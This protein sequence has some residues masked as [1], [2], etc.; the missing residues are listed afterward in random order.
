M[1]TSYKV[2]EKTCIACP[3]QL[4]HDAS[5]GLNSDVIS[6]SMHDHCTLDSQQHKVSA[7]YLV[8]TVD[9]ACAVQNLVLVSGED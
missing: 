4:V 1:S 6:L 7:R 3:C 5:K 9:S 2:S 8:P